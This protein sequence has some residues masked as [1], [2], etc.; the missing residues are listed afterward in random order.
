M[1]VTG[2]AGCTA[3]DDELLTN[4][5]T[6]SVTFSNVAPMDL[7]TEHLLQNGQVDYLAVQ[8]V[9]SCITTP[10]RKRRGNEGCVLKVITQVAQ[11]AAGIALP[12]A[13]RQHS[14]NP[15]PLA[16]RD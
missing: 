3:N 9:S 6:N 11:Q 16:T 12:R 1:G 8:S 15:A 10:C 4:K 14:R 13:E 7:I 5:P 2:A